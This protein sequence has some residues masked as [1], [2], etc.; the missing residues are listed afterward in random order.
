MCLKALEPMN[1][2]VTSQGKAVSGFQDA[3]YSSSAILLFSLVVLW[4]QVPWLAA[5]AYCSWRSF[6]TARTR[7]C[8]ATTTPELHTVDLDRARWGGCCQCATVFYCISNN[9]RKNDGQAFWGE[10]AL[11]LY[12]RYDHCQGHAPD[13]LMWQSPWPLAKL[14]ILQNNKVRFS[15]HENLNPGSARSP[16]WLTIFEGESIE[17]TAVWPGM[18][19]QKSRGCS[20]YGKPHL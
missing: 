18:L 16:P 11:E 13:P 15:C 6:C 20:S 8:T 4:L 9:S 17:S 7:W 12:I 3:A 2:Q 14:N 1:C 10:I 5:Q 19:F